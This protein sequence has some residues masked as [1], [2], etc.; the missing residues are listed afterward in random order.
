MEGLLEL[1]VGDIKLHVVTFNISRF[2]V[3]RVIQ[4]STPLFKRTLE[5]YSTISRILHGKHY[6]QESE[7]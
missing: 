7:Q 6:Y 4:R 5:E 2:N 1:E 3:S